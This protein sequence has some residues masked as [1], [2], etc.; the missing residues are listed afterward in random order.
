MWD[1]TRFPQEAQQPDAIQNKRLTFLDNQI[2]RGLQPSPIAAPG[3]RQDVR[4]LLRERDTAFDVG[5]VNHH[6]F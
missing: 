2:M 5:N 4:A 1:C 6:E 3:R